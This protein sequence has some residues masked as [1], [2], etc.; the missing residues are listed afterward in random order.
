MKDA[1]DL[2][3]DEDGII[4]I[5]GGDLG[6]LDSLGEGRTNC[7][8]NCVLSQDDIDAVV[9][10]INDALIIRDSG[11]L[12]RINIHIPVKLLNEKN[13]NLLRAFLDAV[14]VYVDNGNIRWATQIESYKSSIDFSL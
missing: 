3:P 5:M 14:K 9:K 1:S 4:T 12:A 7:F 8:P 11:R 13:E 10:A 2:L 6:E